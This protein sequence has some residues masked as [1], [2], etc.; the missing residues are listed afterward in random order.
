MLIKKPADIRSSEITS[1]DNYLNRRSFIRA[2]SIAGASLL[3]GP[4]IS[5]IVPDESLAKLPGVL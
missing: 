5:G 3:A 1:K 2:G 4:A